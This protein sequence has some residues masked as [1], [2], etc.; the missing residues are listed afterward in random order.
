M[1]KLPIYKNKSL[2][3][4][5]GEQWREIPSTEEHYAVSN[6]GRV[7]SLERITYNHRMAPNG[8]RVSERILCLDISKHYNNHTHD[9]V[10]ELSVVF[11]FEMKR[12]K[13]M[14][15]RLV[16][17]AFV[18]PLKNEK[19]KGMLV[20]PKD[21]N[22]YNCKAENLA[23][24]TRSELRRRGFQNDR[25]SSGFAKQTKEQRAVILKKINRI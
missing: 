13:T 18:A 2:D 16:Y 17:E 20:Y 11:T 15:G 7:K 22:G 25:Y 5:K 3:D 1:P 19:M 6:L 10:I 12:F 4:L 21:G 23:L 14:V 24:T 8:R 9:Y